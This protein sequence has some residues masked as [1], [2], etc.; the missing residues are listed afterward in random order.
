MLFDPQRLNCAMLRMVF[1]VSLTVSWAR[2]MAVSST[3]RR[4]L[5]RT[6]FGFDR[7]GRFS[8]KR[9]PGSISSRASFR[10]SSNLSRR[11][12]FV[13]GRPKEAA[14]LS[15]VLKLMVESITRCAELLAE[16]S[17]NTSR[18]SSGADVVQR[19]Q[20]ANFHFLVTLFFELLKQFELFR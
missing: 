4:L 9:G 19:R 13:I 17:R 16:F 2:E 8:V 12:V 14:S 3:S 1:M 15:L 18:A 11:I 5:R 10:K 20:D 7:R 6:R